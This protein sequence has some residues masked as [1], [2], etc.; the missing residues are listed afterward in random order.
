[1]M[2]TQM[3]LCPYCGKWLE[4]SIDPSVPKQTYIE[5]CQICCR[6]I[7]LTITLSGI[8]GT[9]VHVEARTEED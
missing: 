7:T 6:P 2:D 4:I 5:D 1:M 8:D 9:D 3:A